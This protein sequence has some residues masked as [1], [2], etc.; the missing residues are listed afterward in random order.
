MKSKN[1]IIV[2]VHC[3]SLSMLLKHLNFSKMGITIAALSSMRILSA[4]CNS[5]WTFVNL[6]CTSVTVDL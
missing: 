2:S 6:V 4:F 3:L 5:C 1:I